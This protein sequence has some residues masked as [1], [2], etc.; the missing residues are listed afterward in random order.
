MDTL[1]ELEMSNV[2]KRVIGDIIALEDIKLD[3]VGKVNQYGNIPPDLKDEFTGGSQLD[4]I[5]YNKEQTKL[6][7]IAIW[8]EPN[9]TDK[10]VLGEYVCLVNGDPEIPDVINKGYMTMLEAAK[11]R[12]NYEYAI[13]NHTFD[14]SRE[15]ISCPY[16]NSLI[17]GLT[18]Q[19]KMVSPN[20]PIVL[21]EFLK[22]MRALVPDSSVYWTNANL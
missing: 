1:K 2:S 20:K 15:V 13:A 10:W 8:T 6:F 4:W 18:I 17:P 21:E 5:I 14:T 11:Y 16:W 19:T 3:D 9:T 22:V 7:C 12:K